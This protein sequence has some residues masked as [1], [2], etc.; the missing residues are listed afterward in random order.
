MP[1][2][3]QICEEC[4]SEREK[5]D[6]KWNDPVYMKRGYIKIGKQLIGMC[7]ICTEPLRLD[8][9]PHVYMSYIEMVD[10]KIYNF[11]WEVEANKLY[12][13]GKIRSVRTI[14]AHFQRQGNYGEKLCFGAIKNLYLRTKNSWK[15]VGE[16]CMDCFKI[17]WNK[18]FL[19][20]L[21]EQ[22]KAALVKLGAIDMPDTIPKK[23]IKYYI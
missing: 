5:F 16:I 14:P 10:Q 2:Q 9:Y 19:E 13:Q 1:R 18:E 11:S 21:Y 12:K 3:Y 6:S 23:Y 7:W 17:F 20:D 8:H 4:K 22:S 15:V